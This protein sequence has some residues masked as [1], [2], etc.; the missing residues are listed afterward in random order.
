MVEDAD[1]LDV[2]RELRAVSAALDGEA[3]DLE[4][5]G[6]QASAFRDTAMRIRQTVRIEEAAVPPDVTSAVLQQLGAD[7]RPAPRRSPVG[8]RRQGLLVAGLAFL[9]AAVVGAL[10]VNPGWRDGGQAAVADVPEQLLSAQRDLDELDA[11]VTLVEQGAHP[12]VPVRRYQGTLRYRAPEELSLVLKDVSARPRRWPANDFELVIDD[13]AVWQSG[14]NDCPVADQPRCLGQPDTQA[15]VGLAPFAPD[16][17]APLDLVIPT[18]GFVA[19]AAIADPAVVWREQD[20]VVVVDATVAQVQP[21]VEAV[22][23]VG[24]VR[25]VHSS[26]PVRLRLD[27]QTLSLLGLSVRAGS[28]DGRANWAAANGYAD[29]AGAPLL[30][31]TVTPTGTPVPAPAPA[32]VTGTARDGGFVD[33]EPGD[34]LVVTDVPEG[35]EP[36]RVGRLAVGG[37]LTSVRSY[38]DGRAWF[39]VAST[40]AWDRPQLF[41]DLGP[42]VRSVDVGQGVGYVTPEGDVLSLHAAGIDVVVRGT[43][44]SDLLRRIAAGLARDGGPVSGMPLPPDWA[45]ADLLTDLPAGTLRPPG[46]LTARALPDGRVVV[47]IPGTGTSGATLT[48][49]PGEVLPPPVKADVVEVEVRGRAG[50]W[51]APLGLLVWQEN[52]WIHELHS[53]GLDREGLTAVTETLLPV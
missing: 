29:P 42:A 39:T 27:G 35:F 2:Q 1:D 15:A 51:S 13:G 47:A 6:E 30:D 44:P 23:G 7:A 41:G 18:G 21:L 17:Q 10:V 20:G 36:H 4:D 3:P 14:L 9:A 5:L 46:P 43:V 22:T 48:Q 33:G 26:D 19:D 38:S 37:P 25:Q 11:A 40:T 12:Q 53:D 34:D 16:V 52:G 8:P 24:A 28:G 50:R 49:R 45:Q 31:L 32:P